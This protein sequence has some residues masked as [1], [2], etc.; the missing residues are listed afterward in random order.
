MWRRRRFKHTNTDAHANTDADAYPDADA[1]S[2]ADTYPDA[3][4]H[5]RTCRTPEPKWVVDVYHAGE[6]N[7]LARYQRGNLG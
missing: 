7:R 5:A 2:D 3:D 4:T 6:R 1:Y